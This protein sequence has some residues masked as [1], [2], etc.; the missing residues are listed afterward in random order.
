MRAGAALLAL[1]SILLLSCGGG[2]SLLPKSGGRP[3]EVLVV[4]D[5]A[6]CLAITD[7]ILSID[8]GALPQSEPCFNV[9]TTDSRRF[10]DAVR[11]ARNIV[12]VTVDARRFTATRIRYEKN[13]WSRPQMV[14]Y[15]NTPSSAAFS[16]DMQKLAPQLLSLF[17]RAE[18]NNDIALLQ[19]ASNKR[20]EQKVWQ[21][22]GV[23]IKLPA[24]MKS[25]KQGRDFL[26]L[27]DNGTASM[28]SIC[29]YSYPSGTLD[30]SAAASRRDSV[31]RLNIPG[32]RQGMYMQTVPGSVISELVTERGRNIMIRRGLWEMR[33]DAMGGPF[34]SHSMVDTARR[35]VIVA[36]AFVYAPGMKKR[37]LVRRAEAALYTMKIGQDDKRV[38]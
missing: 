37:N 20:A 38:K 18:I 33:G 22:L 29:V 6:S 21:M 1:A 24:D 19:D 2:G 12:I 11:L 23:D 28:S 34:V 25:S 26:W 10:N 5:N 31:M 7:S 17:E 3:Y 16:K 8:A 13:V 32:E 15:I 14:V 4:S 30:V 27:S 35:R 36:E 9:S